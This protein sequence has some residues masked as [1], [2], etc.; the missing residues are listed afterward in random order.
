MFMPPATKIKKRPGAGS[1]DIRAGRTAIGSAQ[2][3]R[4][5]VGARTPQTV[6]LDA[7]HAG[8]MRR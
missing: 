8:W 2:T 5:V 3:L 1:T 7:R 4:A 6:L